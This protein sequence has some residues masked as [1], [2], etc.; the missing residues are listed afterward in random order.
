MSKDIKWDELRA[1]FKNEDVGWKAIPSKTQRDQ[2]KNKQVKA[3]WCDKA[4]CF[5]HP[6]S[7]P[8]SYVGHAAVT[9]R[10]LDFDPMWNWEFLAT[11]ERGMPILD[12]NGGL[13]ITLTIQGVTR[14]GYGDAQANG[15][16]K[17]QG[18]LI[19]EAI[20]DAIR[21]A[22]MRFGVALEL[23]HKGEFAKDD[24][25]NDDEPEP[26]QEKPQYPQDRFDE[27]LKGWEGLI[28]EGVTPQTII[29]QI[30]ARYTLTDDQV[31]T[32]MSIGGNDAK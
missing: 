21:N 32:I 7:V 22:A 19:K 26:K 14:K 25:I 11:D 27:K 1:P 30:A 12:Q 3:V 20:G 10:L 4:Q 9:K 23:W 16:N 29:N 31:R 18:D 6:K 5:R 2:L 13:W 17:S 15:S 24:D 28:S 8:L